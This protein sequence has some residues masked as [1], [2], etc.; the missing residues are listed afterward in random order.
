MRVSKGTK[1]GL[2]S[3]VGRAGASHLP[4]G[5]WALAPQSGLENGLSHPCLVRRMSDS[6]VYCL[7]LK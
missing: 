7:F 5:R 1:L 3:L 2:G 6:F 4:S